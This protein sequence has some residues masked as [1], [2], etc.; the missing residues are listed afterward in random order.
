MNGADESEALP[1]A[2]VEIVRP[3]GRPALA[4]TLAVRAAIAGAGDHAA[5]RFLEFFAAQIRNRN[6]RMAY[7]HVVCTFFARLDRHDI[8]EIADIEAD[9]SGSNCRSR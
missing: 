7:Y 6:T 1:P 2:I 9:H 3:V 5:R 4:S 8:R